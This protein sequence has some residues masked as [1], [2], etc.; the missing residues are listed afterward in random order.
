[1]PVNSENYQRFA[2]SFRH[3]D[4]EFRARDR[5]FRSQPRNRSRSAGI[6]GHDPPESAV[7]F[8]RNQWSRSAGIRRYLLS[9]RIAKNI[10]ERLLIDAFVRGTAS[11]T[12]GDSDEATIAELLQVIVPDEWARDMHLFTAR[13]F[14]D[15]VRRGETG[16]PILIDAADDALFR[17][18]LGWRSR[19]RD[20]GARVT[21]VEQC[22]AYLNQ[23]IDDIWEEV[24]EELGRYAREPL[25]LMLIGNHESIVIETDRWSR[26]ARAVLAFRQNKGEAAR[27]SA[28]HVAK[29]NGASL[30]TRILIAMALCDCPV[31]G[32][33]PG[34][35]DISRLMV[36][37]MQMHHLGGWSEAIRYRGKVDEIR[38]TPLGDIHTH[39]EFDNQVATPYGVA[40]GVKRLEHGADRYEENFHEVDPLQTARGKLDDAFWDAWEQTFGFTIDE[41]RAFMDN[42]DDEGLRRECLVFTASAEEMESYS[43][44]SRLP[45]DVVRNILELLALRPRS[46]WASTPKG[47]LARLWG[48]S[49]YVEFSSAGRAGAVMPL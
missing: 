38:I 8:N 40:L 6:S 10:G 25:L 35:I 17:L 18:G 49:S 7:T 26:T 43:T 12:D 20:E 45:P 34:R 13:T 33:L 39:I 42:L 37:V 41:L 29:L 1:M 24:K 23:V 2:V 36:K 4:R 14:R 19:E 31:Q 16:N 48:V 9:F 32:E 28:Q 5:R 3:R 21:G 22:C 47:F 46:T 27:E 15:F 30:A 44:H 11:L